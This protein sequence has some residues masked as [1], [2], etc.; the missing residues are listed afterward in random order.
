MNEVQDRSMSEIAQ[1]VLL[2]FPG[3]SPDEMWSLHV[4]T[5]M[6][7]AALLDKECFGQLIELLT[8]VDKANVDTGSHGRLCSMFEPLRNF[9]Q[10]SRQMMLEALASQLR[11]AH[12]KYKEHLEFIASLPPAKAVESQE[13]S[14]GEQFEVDIVFIAEATLLF[15]QDPSL[16]TPDVRLEMIKGV[17]LDSIRSITLDNVYEGEGDDERDVSLESERILSIGD[18]TVSIAGLA[19]NDPEAM[20]DH[21]KS[22]LIEDLAAFGHSNVT[23]F[24][25]AA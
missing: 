5:V 16:L 17:L 11:E 21:I 23:G 12:A 3:A 25:T 1:Q 4:A 24:E 9:E 7:K 8:D 18:I 19:D 2:L 10:L 15:E 20:L 22:K 13:D 14:E 6:E